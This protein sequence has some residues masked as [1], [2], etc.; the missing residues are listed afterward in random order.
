MELA[1]KYTGVSVGVHGLENSLPFNISLYLVGP[2]G[3]GIGAVFYMLYRR[4]RRLRRRAIRH[5]SE[6]SRRLE[7]IIDRKRSS[8]GLTEEGMTQ[9]NDK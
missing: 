8:S 1:G 3:I 6:Q 2:G 5:L 7:Q 4:E 9:P